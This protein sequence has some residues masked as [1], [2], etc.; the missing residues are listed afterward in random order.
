MFGRFILSSLIAAAIVTIS[1]AQTPDGSV[2]IGSVGLV[3]S[4]EDLGNG[5]YRVSG[6][7]YDIW[8]HWDQFHYM[9]FNRTGDVTVT[10]RVNDFTGSTNTWMKGGIMF[11]NGIYKDSYPNI[12][13]RSAHSMIQLTGFGIAH[14]TR[15]SDLYHSLN[16]N[17]NSYSITNVWMKLVKQGST[18]T[19]YIKRDGEFGFMKYHSVEV[20]FTENY[21]VGI[22]VTS[23]ENDQLATI[24]ITDFEISDEVFTLPGDPVE[25]GS[26]GW[27]VEV[28]E[29]EEGKW[30]MKAGGIIGGTE[31]SFGSFFTES[32]GDITASLHLNKLTRY[33][34]D[35]K[36]GLM[37][38]DTT[39]PD[40]AH[41]SLLVNSKHGVTMYWRNAAG[42]STN[43]KN[44]GVW[45]ED[46]LLRLIKTG[47]NVEASYKHQA[48]TD[49]FVLGTAPFTPT[50][51]TFYVGKVT[52]SGQKYYISEMTTTG[53]FTVTAA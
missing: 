52:S 48:A 5:A 3:G 28:Q 44:M 1:S 43:S 4:S 29:V 18:I 47:N 24:D 10:C 38:R 11:R 15:P 39:D 41:V 34:N 19:S 25:I 20:E 12:E 23:H 51:E 14:Q 46:V 40:S 50:S 31:D 21:H 42:Q 27:G 16:K 8:G 37:I 30:S 9:Y 13:G 45:H 36:G 26:T 49:W 33:N 35:S 32:S 6:S 22:A 53:E 17:K 2:D 7:G